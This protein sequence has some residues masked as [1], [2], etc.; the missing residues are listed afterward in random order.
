MLL[1]CEIVKPLPIKVGIMQA[2]PNGLAWH[3]MSNIMDKGKTVPL[4]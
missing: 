3:L 2:C 4:H 1:Y